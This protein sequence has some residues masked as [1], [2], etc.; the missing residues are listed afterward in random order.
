MMY[1]MR[2]ATHKKGLIKVIYTNKNELVFFFSLKLIALI[3]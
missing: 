3:F 1:N 2:R